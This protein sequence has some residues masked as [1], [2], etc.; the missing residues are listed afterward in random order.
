MSS[1]SGEVPTPVPAERQVLVAVHAAAVGRSD[2][3]MLR[4]RPPVLMRLMIGLLE[5][6]AH[7]RHGLRRRRRKRR[8]G[9]HVVQAGRS[10]LRHARL[11]ELG[12]HAEYVPRGGRRLH[13]DDPRRPALRGGR[14][15]RGR[16]LRAFVPGDAQVQTGRQHPRLWRIRRHRHRGGAACHRHGRARHRGRR[17]APCRARES[18]GA[19]RVIDYTKEDFT[20]IGETFDGVL[21]AV[22]KTTYLRCRRLLK[23]GRCS[24]APIWGPM[25]RR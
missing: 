25:A 18:L 16:V 19:E 8:Q 3:G 1:R 13:R 12:A 17:H 21:D 6:A 15:L 24:S 14:G 22:G 10:R 11:R 5:A 2:C 7:P 23:P 20:R 4:P 9:R